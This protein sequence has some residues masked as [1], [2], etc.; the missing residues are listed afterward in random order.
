VALCRVL[1]LKIIKG[2]VI[3]MHSTYIHIFRAIFLLLVS[4]PPC[5]AAVIDVPHKFEAGKASSA[6]DVNKNFSELAGA[7]NDILEAKAAC[8][9]SGPDDEMVRVGSICVDKYEASVWDARQNGTQITQ[10][11]SCLQDTSLNPD[12]KNCY[13]H[14]KGNNCSSLTQGVL[15]TTSAIYARSKKGVKAAAWFTWFQAQQACANVGKRLL[16]N[17]EWQMAAAGTNVTNCDVDSG[18]PILN[19]TGSHVQCISNWG[20]HDMVGG[21]WERVADWIH[22]RGIATAASPSG[23]WAPT[24]TS[25]TLPQAVAPIGG[26]YGITDVMAGVNVVGRDS[27]PSTLGNF[28][29]AILRGGSFDWGPINSG[30]FALLGNWSPMDMTVSIGF[31]CGR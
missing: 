9:G 29:A 30:E 19:N 28:P 6:A 7:I 31:R 25:G 26:Q 1:Q 5:V 13:C 16:T 11:A 12:P 8:V 20:V 10:N 15:N 21:L 24:F 27:N 4:I 3:L 18:V 22:G 2:I 23:A 17:A 14:P